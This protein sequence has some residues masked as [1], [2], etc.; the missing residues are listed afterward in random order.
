VKAAVTLLGT[1]LMLV[2]QERLPE[3]ASRVEGIVIN[4][5]SNEGIAGARLM[6]RQEGPR[7]LI[8]ATTSS[9]DGH[10]VLKNLPAGRYR[11]S[12]AKQGFIGQP[13]LEDPGT[14]LDLS[15]APPV[16][17]ITVRLTP[18]AVI[19]GR[20]SDDKGTAL[21]RVA[22]LLFEREYQSDGKAYLAPVGPVCQW[23]D[24]TGTNDLGEYRMPWVAPG[25]YYVVALK[26]DEFGHPSSTPIMEQSEEPS[27]LFPPTFYPNAL[28]EAGA[29]PLRIE[30]GAQLSGID[31]S[32]KGVKPLRVSGN[33]LSYGNGQPVTGEDVKLKRKLWSGAIPG[34][35]DTR[36]TDAAGNFEFEYVLPGEYVISVVTSL[37]GF[38]TLS[39]T[40]SLTVNDRPI[41]GIRIVPRPYP[42][43]SGQLIL[44]TN[45]APETRRASLRFSNT[46]TAHRR[47]EYD[48][49][50]DSDGTFQLSN[51]AP[52]TYK[53]SLTGFSANSFIRSATSGNQDALGLG[54]DVRD[55]SADNLR[56][57]VGSNGGSLE[58][59][60]NKDTDHP[61]TGAT[62]VLLPD[63]RDRVGLF[64]TATTDQ[65][66]H[67]TI[68][69]VLPGPYRVLAFTSLEPNIY[70]DPVFTE[71]YESQSK[72]I[73]IDEGGHVQLRLT[74]IPNPR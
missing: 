26:D 25:T 40:Q 8:Y 12:A 31:F 27:D 6:V 14:V 44:E 58:G 52:G 74:A 1:L 11:L 30:P 2:T 48:A 15:N 32:L 53:I 62:V 28:D 24:F 20:V 7:P 42:T 50:V 23:C 71:M 35:E 21:E 59:V 10:F 55:G 22:I 9:S 34:P 56:I 72:A 16:Q 3:K 19:S 67:F 73:T 61:A 64:K 38:R 66:G 63:Q 4:S 70:F 54:L 57:I 47:E 36:R 45:E 65:S 41:S 69:G 60:V 49:G 13:W 46:D 68:R 51:V 17:E 18:G 37:P 29:V 33:V 5:V 43:I 39:D